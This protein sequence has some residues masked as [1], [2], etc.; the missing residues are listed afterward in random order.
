MP[1]TAADLI[2]YSPASVPTDDVGTAGG[3]I[4]TASR[5]DL[6][7][8]SANAVAAV[9]SDG[10]DTR[11]VTVT[12]RLATGVLD[13]EVLVLNG[14]TEV[15]GAK[16]W[17]RVLSLVASATSATR[18]VSVRQGSGG[19]VRATITINETKRHL[20]FQSSASDPSVQRVRHEALWWKN[21]H[22]T[23]ALT[24]ATTELTTDAAGIFRQAVA[25]AKGDTTSVANRL[26]VP[27]GVTFVDD[28]VDQTIPTGFLNPAETIKVWIEQTLAAA[29]APGKGTFTTSLTGATT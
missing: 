10:A 17:E 19:A 6:T 23:L 5:P 7:Q 2:L 29:A 24:T 1:V 16:T 28:G 14:T 8:W 26:A 15:V 3:A 13:T 20:M 25:A 21:T 27:G 4:D 12:G 11:T 22:T 9:V 18:T